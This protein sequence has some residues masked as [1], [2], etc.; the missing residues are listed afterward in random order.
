LE[1]GEAFSPALNFTGLAVVQFAGFLGKAVLGEFSG[2]AQDM[3]MV[4]VVVSPSAGGMNGDIGG[5]AV[6][7]YDFTR[8]IDGKPT[9]FFG[10]K[11][12]G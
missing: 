12:G 6:A 2:A 4:V 11:F 9:P 3:G 5:T 7:V 1:G 10:G 8:K